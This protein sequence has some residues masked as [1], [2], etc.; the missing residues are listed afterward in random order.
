MYDFVAPDGVTEVT[1]DAMSGMLP[2]DH[3]VTTVTELVRTDRQP[4][5]PD[6]LHEELAIEAETANTP[7]ARMFATRLISRSQVNDPARKPP[8]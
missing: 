2:G 8:K 4:T 5:E 1:I 6:T 3:T 7:T